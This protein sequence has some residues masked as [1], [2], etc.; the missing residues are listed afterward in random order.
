[1][2]PPIVPLSAKVKM[3]HPVIKQLQPQTCCSVV[4]YPIS[5]SFLYK[6]A[7]RSIFSAHPFHTIKSKAGPL[8]FHKI[9]CNMA[10]AAAAAAAFNDTVISLN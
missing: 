2:N 4:F 3:L 1:M 9:V 5:F 7:F 8:H 6:S 10:H